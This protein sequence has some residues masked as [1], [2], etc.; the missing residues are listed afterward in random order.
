MRG[1]TRAG[2]LAFSFAVLA[3][4]AADAPSASPPAPAEVSPAPV[5]AS[6]AAVTEA[7]LAD[8]ARRSGLERGALKV[9]SAEA[10]TWSDGSIGCPQPGRLYAQVLVP[11][12]RVRIQAGATL[13]LYHASERG[14][15]FL[16]PQGRALPP[17][18]GR[19]GT[20]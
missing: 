4:C 13:L 20:I 15:P 10:V 17:L 6:L 12:W 8:A 3:A 5:V 14:A 1:S 2:T 18:R 19:S 11:G 16:C 9:L 7:A